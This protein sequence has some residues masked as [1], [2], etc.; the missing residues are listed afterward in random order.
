MGIFSRFQKDDSTPL[1]DESTTRAPAHGDPEKAEDISLGTRLEISNNEALPP[2]ISAEIE[3][4]VLKKLD[5]RLVS[6]VFGLCQ[7]PYANLLD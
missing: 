2:Q 7:S 1:G 5:R 4:R 3:K 6:L